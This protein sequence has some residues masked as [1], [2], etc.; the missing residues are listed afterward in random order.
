MDCTIEHAL[1]ITMWN[2]K[3]LL[4]ETAIYTMLLS[5]ALFEILEEKGLVTRDEVSER[6]KKLVS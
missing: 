1:P 6:V 4:A 2:G 5:H 3:Y